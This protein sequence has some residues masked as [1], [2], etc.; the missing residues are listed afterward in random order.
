MSRRADA[1]N[2]MAG[3]PGPV[4]MEHRSGVGP[5]SNDDP[6]SASRPRHAVREPGRQD[7]PARWTLQSYLSLGAFAEAVPCA[8]LH[9]R[10]VAREWGRRDLVETVELLVSELVTNAVLASADVDG[11]WFRGQRASGRPPVRLWLQ[12]DGQHSIVISVWDGNDGIPQVQEPLPD[13]EH[14]RGLL[15]VESL[16]AECGLYRLEGASGKVVWARVSS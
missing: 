12:R 11:S 16:S 6:I 8:R 7:G 10:L 4:A 13:D 3:Y 2:G 9:A 5:A 15:L 1:V 14:G